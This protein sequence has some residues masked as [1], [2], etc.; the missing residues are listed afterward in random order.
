MSN[1]SFFRSSSTSSIGTTYDVNKKSS[2]NMSF[3]LQ[4]YYLSELNTIQIKLSNL[5]VSTSSVSVKIC[6]DAA[7]DNIILPDTTASI[8]RG[9]TTT[10][11]GAAVIAVNAALYASNENWYIFYKLDAGSADIDDTILSVATH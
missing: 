4:S 9:L 10:T 1:Y 3:S 5:A 8:D 2:I 11:N 6:S 7:G